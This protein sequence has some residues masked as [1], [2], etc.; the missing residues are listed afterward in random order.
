VEGSLCIDGGVFHK[1]G[2]N[3][4]SAK[5]RVLCAFFQS[6]GLVGAYEWK[7]TM[8]GLTPLQKIL[9][10]R[11]LPQV[12]PD[13]MESGKFAYS[14]AYRRTQIALNQVIDENIFLEANF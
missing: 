1:S 10:F 5:E 6:T 13:S 8:N 2:I 7:S 4:A 9:R 3:L 12:R 11:D 14:E